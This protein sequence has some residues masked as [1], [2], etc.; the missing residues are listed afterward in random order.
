MNVRLAYFYILFTYFLSIC[1]SKN[2][3]HETIARKSVYN[4]VERVRN[5]I[6]TTPSTS[7]SDSRNDRT[8]IR[9]MSV[10]E[11]KSAEGRVIIIFCDIDCEKERLKIPIWIREFN[12]N[13]DIPSNDA[14]GYHFHRRRTKFGYHNVDALL[15]KNPIVIIYFIADKTFVYD[16]DVKSQTE[17]NDF[18]M[19]LE[20]QPIQKPQSSEDLDEFISAAS[21][22]DISQKYVLKIHSFKDCYDELWNNL[23]RSF[24]NSKNITFVELRHPLSPEETVIIQQRLPMLRRECQI[25]AVL[26]NGAYQEVVDSMFLKELHKKILNWSNE[27]CSNPQPYAIKMP[28]TEIQLDYLREEL[29]INGIVTNPTYIIVGLIGGIAVIALAIS[30]FWGLNGSSFVTK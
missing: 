29:Y 22:C 25:L 5:K 14:I 28:L 15:D 1:H 13:N 17:F 20:K 21:E 3:D 8:I 26:H 11:A 18:L 7:T 6:T 19:S 4:A 30:I 10:I 23:V 12:A 27:N 2:F 24:H 16:G 9:T